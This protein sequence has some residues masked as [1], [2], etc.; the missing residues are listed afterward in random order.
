MK[1]FSKATPRPWTIDDVLNNL[2]ED[3]DGQDI[4][5]SKEGCPLVTVRGTDD[6]SCM[7]EDE[8]EKMMVEV[9]ANAELIVTAV[10]NFDKM[11]EA[12]TAL[13]T[14]KHVDLGDLVYKVRDS[15][16]KGWEGPS[17]VAWGKAVVNAKQLLESLENS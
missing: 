6:M 5:I 14:N 8:T 7:E 4:I 16:G 11:K 10:N 15:E 1:D 2:D 3:Y 12:L 9:V 13:L 17:V